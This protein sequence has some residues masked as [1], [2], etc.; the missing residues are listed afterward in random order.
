M[1]DIEEQRE[2]REPIKDE[3]SRKRGKE[4]S[5]NFDI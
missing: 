4:I 3:K 2:Q 5:F 1:D